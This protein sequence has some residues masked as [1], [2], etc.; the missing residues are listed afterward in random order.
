M[1]QA[2]IRKGA[3]K[4]KGNPVDLIGPQLKAGDKDTMNK[5]V[6]CLSGRANPKRE[7]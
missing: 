3:V 2:A 6:E 7:R 4:L 1:A 5:L